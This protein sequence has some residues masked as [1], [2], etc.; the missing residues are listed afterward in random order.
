MIYITP[1][2]LV[3][4]AGRPEKGQYSA[5]EKKNSGEIQFF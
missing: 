4:K 1:E 3:A 5:L 2:G